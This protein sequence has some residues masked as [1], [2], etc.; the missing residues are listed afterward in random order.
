MKDKATSKEVREPKNARGTW[1]W[2]ELPVVRH[3]G[4]LGQTMQE[5]KEIDI[6]HFNTSK[7]MGIYTCWNMDPGL[8]VVL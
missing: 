5:W 3:I 1:G 8:Y 2:I 6:K 7:W 4:T